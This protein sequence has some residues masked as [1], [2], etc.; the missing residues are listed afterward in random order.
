MKAGP[1]SNL[2]GLH[3]RKQFANWSSLHW[4]QNQGGQAGPTEIVSCA[5]LNHK[6][7]P[8]LFCALECPPEDPVGLGIRRLMAERAWWAGTAS[9]LLRAVAHSAN[10]N[11]RAGWPKTPGAL[12]GR[13]RRAQTFLRMLGIEICFSRQGRAG[14]RTIR[15]TS[16]STAELGASAPSALLATG[17]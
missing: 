14:T 10:E 9:D 7:K 15:I 16:G 5:S 12:A 17:G 1:S 6:T 8:I 4:Q 13:L 2:T 11:N 3:A